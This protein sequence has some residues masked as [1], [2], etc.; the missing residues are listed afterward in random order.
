M[1]FRFAIGSRA[2]SALLALLI[3]SA[4]SFAACGRRER[5][6]AGRDVF[7]F[8]DHLAEARVEGT[9]PEGRGTETLVFADPL[10][11]AASEVPRGFAPF[12][13]F[14]PPAEASADERAAWSV[15]RDEVSAAVAP[16]PD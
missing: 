2:T 3:V 12:A 11:V 1:R 9:L 13:G 10:E 14:E 4:L 5:P 16:G 7:R 6:S 15:A 8:I